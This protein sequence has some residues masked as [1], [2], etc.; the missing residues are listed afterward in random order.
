VAQNGADL[1]AVC[2]AEAIV[3]G[4]VAPTGYSLASTGAGSTSAGYY[5]TIGRRY[6]LGLKARF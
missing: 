4:C 6:F 2:S 1:A 5:D 3:L